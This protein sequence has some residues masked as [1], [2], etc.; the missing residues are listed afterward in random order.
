VRLSLDTETC[1]AL[2]G[3]VLDALSREP[4]PGSW[5]S[6]V[7]AH[8]L[9]EWGA[10]YKAPAKPLAVEVNGKK[11]KLEPGRK[12][13]ARAPSSKV[14]T[15]T[16]KPPEEGTVAAEVM[17]AYRL[18]HGDLEPVKD[19]SLTRQFARIDKEGNAEVMLPGDAVRLGDSVMMIVQSESPSRGKKQR[20]T[21]VVPAAGPWTTV[22]LTRYPR[23]ARRILREF[24]LSPERRERV[25]VAVEEKRFE[26]ARAELV[27]AVEAADFEEAWIGCDEVPEKCYPTRHTG[28]DPARFTRSSPVVLGFKPDRTGKF[29]APAAYLEVAEGAPPAAAAPPFPFRVV[30]AD[31]MLPV[32]EAELAVDESVRRAVA[33]GLKLVPAE[34][35][36]EALGR[37]TAHV[38]LRPLVIEGLLRSS[39]PE[40]A[41]AYARIAWGDEGASMEVLGSLMDWRNEMLENGRIWLSGANAIANAVLKR[42]LESEEFVQ[43]LVQSSVFR[44]DV[45]RASI[46]TKKTLD[47]ENDWREALY[48]AARQGGATRGVSMR[49]LNFTDVAVALDQE[50]H[51]NLLKGSDHHATRAPSEWPRRSRRRLSRKVSFEFTDTPLS[52]ALVYLEGVTGT[53]IVMD[54]AILSPRHSHGNT[55]ITLKVSNMPLHMALGWILR[56]ADLDYVVKDEAVFISTKERLVSAPACHAVRGPSLKAAIRTWAAGFGLEVGFAPEVPDLE[57][58]EFALSLPE[59]PSVKA[60]DLSLAGLCLAARREGR[61]VAISLDEN[62]A[63]LRP[64]IA[65]VLAEADP[66]ARLRAFLDNARMDGSALDQL[67]RPWERGEDASCYTPR[68]ELNPKRFSS[69]DLRLDGSRP[70]GEQLFSLMAQGLRLETEGGVLKFVPVALSRP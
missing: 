9:A 37:R 69:M 60:L 2:Y 32:R 39:A 26:D 7:A 6:A 57:R 21:V 14:T 61:T 35:L 24:V 30:E 8:A 43:R 64:E 41:D 38:D 36:A 40:A 54:P 27:G 4:R 48:R 13:V 29:I 15:I 1:G 63:R 58:G 18:A 33:E 55:P 53:A 52:E 47:E 50:Q 62:A 44:G 20:P 42:A 51:T 56:L 59:M 34:H 49:L 45:L 3:A 65:A 46:W 70:L 10:L 23:P 22:G 66:E 17:C 31:A 67:A 68:V 19:H 12:A 28:D 25:L 5:A 11:L 16:I